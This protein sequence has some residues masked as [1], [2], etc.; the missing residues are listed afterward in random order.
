MELAGALRCNCQPWLHNRWLWVMSAIFDFPVHALV[1][2]CV[3]GGQHQVQC[4]VDLLNP[5]F[6]HVL[7]RG[8][9]VKCCDM[10]CNVWLA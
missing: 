4:V 3:M 9:R 7:E 1:V 10:R 8:A 6:E 5:T 2:F